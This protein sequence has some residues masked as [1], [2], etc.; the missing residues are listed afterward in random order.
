MKTR[1]RPSLTKGPVTV[2]PLPGP[3]AGREFGPVEQLGAVGEDNRSFAAS[4]GGQ[5]LEKREGSAAEPAVEE[6]VPYAGEDR[7]NEERRRKEY[8]T[9]LDTRKKNPDRRKHRRI[10]LKV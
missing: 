9:T 5:V 3:A 6:T 8:P 1:L 4:R 2:S 7:R 10:S